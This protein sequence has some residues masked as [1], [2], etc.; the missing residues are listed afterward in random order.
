[1]ALS[2]EAKKRGIDKT[3]E[4]NRFTSTGVKF[5]R[6]QEQMESYRSGTGRTVISTHIAPEGACNLKC[7]YCSVTYRDTHNSIDFDTIVD[8]VDK[9]VSRGLKA[10]ILTG[11]GEPTAYKRI[12][13]L[14]EY[15]FDLGLSV[16]MIT[17]G[18]LVEKRVDHDL[19][20]RL[21]W[22]RVS[23][24]FFKGWQERISLPEFDGPIRGCS[25]VFTDLHEEG[26]TDDWET[27]FRQISR[28]ADRCNAEYIRV[29]PNCLLPQPK[30]AAQHRALQHILKRVGDDRFFRQ[31]KHHR[32]PNCGTCHQ[33]YFRPY[34]SEECF[35]DTGVPGS[36]YPCDSVVLNEARAKFTSEYQICKPGDILD[37][38]DGK[39]EQRFDP[40][41]DCS[42][43][44]FTDNVEMLDRWKEGGD[45]WFIQEKIPHEE[46]I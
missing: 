37:Y 11:G 22:I 40:R 34:L 31:D 2:D 15:L 10:V 14:L 41:R 45:G 17:N 33:S 38:L 18:T 39:I 30:L 5:W 6:H 25:V 16:A 29:L 35:G 21:S 8:Y 9:L 46:F 44:V 43:C 26:P 32:S 36:V 12:N 28:V 13:D 27:R 19:L 1:M 24:N 20:K 23:I 42:G 7:P 3:D 4:E